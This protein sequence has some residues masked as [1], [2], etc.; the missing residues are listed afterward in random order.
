M[1]HH[2]KIAAAAVCLLV[3][4]AW[5][6]GCSQDKHRFRSTVF[7]PTTI[8]LRDLVSKKII[9]SK[10]VPVGHD[11][12]MDLDRLGDLAPFRI[13]TTP[14]MSMK[15]WLVKSG[16]ITKVEKGRDK[17]PGV[18][19]II[20]RTHRPAPEYPPGYSPDNASDE[21]ELDSAQTAAELTEQQLHEAMP[22]EPP[23]EPAD[24]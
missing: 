17:L 20:E 13:G 21:D 5:G 24:E 8:S 12:V 1:S 14:A 16:S 9:W 3:L 23:D 4:T 2:G 15:W 19:I 11:L 18:P 6:A 7:H 22:Q 10:E